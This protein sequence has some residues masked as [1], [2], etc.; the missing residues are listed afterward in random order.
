M[1]QDKLQLRESK[2]IGARANFLPKTISTPI[3]ELVLNLRI[4]FIEI[5]QTHILAHLVTIE[6]TRNPPKS[7]NQRKREK[8][9]PRTQNKNHKTQT[10]V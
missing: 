4:S 3:Y 2:K 6:M 10:M 1:A 7:T 5:L 9:E 8:G